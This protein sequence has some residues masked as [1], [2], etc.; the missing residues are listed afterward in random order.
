M[1]EPDSWAARIQWI[2]TTFCDGNRSELAKKIGVSTEAISGLIKGSVP[3]GERLEAIIL[4]FPRINPDWLLT[5]MGPQTRDYRPLASPT[6]AQAVLERIVSIM[7]E[8]EAVGD[9]IIP[10]KADAEEAEKVARAHDEA[11]QRAGSRSSDRLPPATQDRKRSGKREP[12]P[13]RDTD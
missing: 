9:P 2:V 10:V 7:G 1:Q 5:G 11:R 12:R 3:S 13:R 8:A 6:K 4:A